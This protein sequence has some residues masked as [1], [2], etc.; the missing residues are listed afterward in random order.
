MTERRTTE[1]GALWAHNGTKGTAKNGEP[2]TREDGTTEQRT[3]EQK[4]KGTKEPGTRWAHKGT[5]NNGAERHIQRLPGA[6]ANK[7]RE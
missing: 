4:N 1:P 7:M 2:R 5:K 6:Q 3:T